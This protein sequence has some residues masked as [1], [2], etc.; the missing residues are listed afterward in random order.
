MV[1]SA[2]PPVQEFAAQIGVQTVG[3]FDSQGFV[4]AIVDRLGAPPKLR[5]VK[6]MP[7]ISVKQCVA[8][9]KALLGLA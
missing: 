9:Q 3:F 1:A 4:Q 8:A 6:E 2:T 7:Q 5:Q